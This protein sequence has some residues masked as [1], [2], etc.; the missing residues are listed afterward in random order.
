MIFARPPRSAWP[1]AAWLMLG[2]TVGVGGFA[3]LAGILSPAL[4]IDLVSLWP[5]LAIAVVSVPIVWGARRRSHRIQAVPPLLALTW[6]VLATAAH[7]SGWALLPSSAAEL[8][9]PET[10]TGPVR[11]QVSLDGPLVVRAGASGFLY[12]VRFLRLGGRV[13]PPVAEERQDPVEIR[14]EEED[15]SPWFRF[16]G[17][18]TELAVEPRW[19][20]WLDPGPGD[21][22]VDLTGL[23]VERIRVGGAGTVRLGGGAGS[24]QVDGTYTVVVPQGVPVMVVGSAI[25]PD[26]WIASDGGWRAPVEGEG[27]MIEVGSGGSVAMVVR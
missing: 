6:I 3:V 4:V 27:W 2:F 1:T 12:Q 11:L 7:L 14:I 20:L 16:S 5:G 25:V 19:D 21:A 23:E 15:G 13:G 9:G 18:R 10:M 22:E 24:M 26:D 8:V 17:W